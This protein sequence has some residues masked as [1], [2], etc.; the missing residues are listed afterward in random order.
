MFQF[1]L[2]H[3]TYSFLGDC[4]VDLTIADMTCIDKYSV[5]KEDEN[6]YCVGW[7]SLPCPTREAV[8]NITSNAWKFT[9]AVDL[10]G[11]PTIGY[12]TTYGGADMWP[13]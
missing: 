1:C 6:N 8:Y 13:I 7:E 4:S 12:H 11:L 3:R 2:L 9:P 10:W 5:L